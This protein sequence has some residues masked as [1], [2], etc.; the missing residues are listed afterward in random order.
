LP[1]FAD[2]RRGARW[3]RKQRGAK[4]QIGNNVEACGDLNTGTLTPKNRMLTRNKPRELSLLPC[5]V[6]ALTSRAE[7]TTGGEQSRTRAVTCNATVEV[8]RFAEEEMRS[9]KPC[10][11]RPYQGVNRLGLD[12]TKPDGGPRGFHGMLSAQRLSRGS[13]LD[14]YERVEKAYEKSASRFRKASPLRSD[15]GD[16]RCKSSTSV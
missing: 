11:G 5:H 1:W 12:S 2:S 3:P 6:G 9:R 7:S 4:P 13:I 10:R 14:I 16:V 15:I 8:M